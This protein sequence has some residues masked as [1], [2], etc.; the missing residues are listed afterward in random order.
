MKQESNNLN[1]LKYSLILLL[2]FSL[3]A[4]AYTITPLNLVLKEVS[5]TA[6][7][8]QYQ[9][10]FYSYSI[11]SW[12]T[13]GMFVFTII[14]GLIAPFLLG[15]VV[16]LQFLKGKWLPTDDPNLEKVLHYWFKLVLTAFV[17]MLIARTLETLN[18]V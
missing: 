18:F 5:R 2:A 17:L 12:V 10:M 3:S 14:L 4:I 16:V 1:I 8:L 13:S 6:V 11:F 7:A 9:W 15:I